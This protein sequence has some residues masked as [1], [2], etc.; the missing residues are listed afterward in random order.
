VF[1]AF[2]K[3]SVG[4]RLSA[5]VVAAL[6]LVLTTGVASGDAKPRATNVR[7]GVEKLG[8]GSSYGLFQQADDDE[9]KDHNK[10]KDKCPEPPPP[11]PPPPPPPPP[12]PPPPPPP[13]PPAP[14]PPPPPA[15]PPPPPPE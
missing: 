7:I 9:C 15:P 5:V 4:L 6:A 13:P 8:S 1:A 2:F 10:N 14:E 11:E 12:A 3:T